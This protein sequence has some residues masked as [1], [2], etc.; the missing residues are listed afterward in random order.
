MTPEQFAEEYGIKNAFMVSY[1]GNITPPFDRLADRLSALKEIKWS[2]LGDASTPLPEAELGNTEEL[3]A[4]ARGRANISGGVVDDF[5]SPARTKR[6]TPK[7]LSKMKAELNK[8]GLDFW[9]VLYAHE[10]EQELEA[11]LPCFD[12]ITF[13]IWRL[14]ELK[15]AEQY[16]KRVKFLAKGKP[17]MLGIYLWD[18]HGERPMEADAFEKQLKYY[19]GLLKQGNIEG[20]IFCSGA[21]GDLRL[22]SNEI[23]KRYIAENGDTEI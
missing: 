11:Y 2:V 7:V 18:Y 5:F 9:C 20:V 13:W 4:A 3:V 12:G 17:L 1:G 14:E 6:F 10:L 23:L 15:N 21:I 8:N 19:F 22:E 16:F